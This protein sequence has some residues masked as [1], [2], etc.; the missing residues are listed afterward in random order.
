MQIDWL[1]HAY[2]S[3]THFLPGKVSNLVLRV[4]RLHVPCIMHWP[5]QAVFARYMLTPLCSI[6]AANNR[7]LRVKCLHAFCIKRR[8][9]QVRF[10]GYKPTSL[11]SMSARNTHQIQVEKAHVLH[12]TRGPFQL[13]LC[14]LQ[15]KSSASLIHCHWSLLTVWVLPCASQNEPIAL[16]SLACNS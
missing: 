13:V 2:S 8:Y 10:A 3:P 5:S 7:L 16:T 11:Y 1:N 6:S 4:E 15:A 14:M 9:P 12:I